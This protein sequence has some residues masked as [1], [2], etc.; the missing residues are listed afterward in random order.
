MFLEEFSA[1]TTVLCYFRP[2]PS[3]PRREKS[4]VLVRYLH[5]HIPVRTGMLGPCAETS[6]IP[7]LGYGRGC[8]STAKTDLSPSSRQKK[9]I[10]S[11]GPRQRMQ[12]QRPSA[13]FNHSGSHGTGTVGTCSPCV[14]CTTKG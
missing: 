2:L 7:S 4:T 12:L 13:R 3:R 6:K 1:L 9:E 14:L 11:V 10:N 8:K 5:S